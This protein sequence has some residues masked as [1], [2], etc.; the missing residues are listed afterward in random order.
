M[1]E[2]DKILLDTYMCGFNDELDGRTRMWNPNPLLLRAYN[3]GRQD[4]IIGDDVRSVD[5]QTD[6]EIV[7]RIRNQNVY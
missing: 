6:E 2:Q 3:L 1:N 4:A 7:N 5:Y